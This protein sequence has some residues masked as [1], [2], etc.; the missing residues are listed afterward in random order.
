MEQNLSALDSRR[1]N[2]GQ[3]FL[4]AFR[5]LEAEN[6]LLRAEIAALRRALRLD[7]RSRTVDLLADQFRAPSDKAH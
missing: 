6:I 2:A 7:D 5:N 1:V 3:M 4:D